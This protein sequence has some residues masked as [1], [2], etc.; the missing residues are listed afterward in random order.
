MRKPADPRD[1]AVDLLPRSPSSIRVSSV[2]ADK[3]GIISWGWNG[4]GATGYGEHAERAAIRR[5]N[6]NRLRGATI[7]VAGAYR[8]KNKIVCARPCESCR[9][10][11]DKYDLNVI[12]R[13][14]DGRWIL[15]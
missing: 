14:R 2:I 5:A 15:D 6:R 7:Y 9:P 13:D 1:L 4:P 10:L 8:D 11:V 3:W 12:Y